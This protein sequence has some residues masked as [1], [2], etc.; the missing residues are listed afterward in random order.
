MGSNSSGPFG[1]G[2]RFVP[3][4]TTSSRPSDRS[5]LPDRS[6]DSKPVRRLERVG[7]A[8]GTTVFDFGAPAVP[9]VSPG[10]IP[11]P[12]AP[13]TFD[14]R[15]PAALPPT[16]APGAASPDDLEAFRRRWIKA[17]MQP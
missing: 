12:G 16:S 1:S 17:F 4:A 11:R 9:L 2:G 7:D 8:P 3:R 5:A 13:A 6:D 10:P 15:F 14:E